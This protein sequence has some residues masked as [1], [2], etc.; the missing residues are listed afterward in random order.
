MR[1]GAHHSRRNGGDV[2]MITREFGA[3]RI[4]KT[5]Q[6]KLTRAICSQVRHGDFAT[7]GRNVDD[8]PA[9]TATHLRNYFPYE[10]ERR[11]Q[12]Q[13]HGALEIVARHMFER[14]DFDD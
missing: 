8:A 2:D 14:A 6:R 13:L 4:R 5:N 7:D 1:T 12:M 3:H 10:R 9:T 11:P